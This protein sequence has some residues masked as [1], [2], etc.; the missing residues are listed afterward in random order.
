M[1]KKKGF[2]LIELLAT[3]IILALVLSI[4]IYLALAIIRKTRENSYK[5]TI[6]EI[7]ANANN[8]LL[9]NKG[10]LTFVKDTDT[11]EYQCVTVQKLID[12]GY[13]DNNVVK[14]Q[15]NEKRTVNK[16]DY[17]YLER[18]TNTK[19]ITKSIYLGKNLSNEEYKEYFNKCGNV[20]LGTIEATIPSGW[21]RTKEII[22]IY[23]L[24]NQDIGS[25]DKYQYTWNFD[26]SGANE[27]DN[28]D[29]D[30]GHITTVEINNNGTVTAAIKDESGEIVSKTF[31]IDEIDN[32]G[33][34]IS[35]TDNTN[36]EVSGTVTIPIKVTDV[37][38]GV[39]L[40]SFTKEDIVVKIGDNVVD[41]FTLT[42][43]GN[44]NYDLVINDSTHYG[45]VTIIIDKDKVFDKVE[46]G[47]NLTELKPDV[48]FSSTYTITYNGNGNT[49][50]M[51]NATT[52]PNN[53]DC[54]LSS[55]GFTKTGFIFD[56]WYSE[57]TGGTKYGST[58]KLTSNTT[59]Y[60]HWKAKTLTI[61]YN[62]NGGT[63]G[64]SKTFTYGVSGQAFPN[65][66]LCSRNGY[67]GNGWSWNAGDANATYGW[68][69]GVA[70][71]WI[72]SNSRG[73]ETKTLYAHWKINT[74]TISY[75]GNGNTGGMTNATTCNYNTTCTLSSNG[76]SKNGYTFDGWYTAASGGTK[77]GSTTI[78]T[79]N[80]TVYAHW[81]QNTVSIYNCFD[82][83]VNY[84]MQS[85]PFQDAYIE[86]MGMKILI[87]S[88]RN[89]CEMWAKTSCENSGGGGG[90]SCTMTSGDGP[91][92]PN[93]ECQ[94]QHCEP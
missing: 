47:N 54:P 1:K 34:V 12:F 91:G 43:K 61:T 80:T 79:S 60:A 28:Q 38:S 69:S 5:V 37:G 68:T 19:A 18:D 20:I 59:V 31:V 2:T 71:S 40:D 89:M 73:N 32:V 90:C 64:G 44:G 92:S 78:L 52:C 27:K 22:I 23:R 65:P 26:N 6:N 57:A 13:L 33:P 70:D 74:Y 11:T 87:S 76:F 46:N 58:I 15:I 94:V 24:K 9:E 39:D 17:V 67:T 16:N 93:A 88:K 45:K 35:L 55:N 63:G 48:T 25:T 29:T 82:W 21:S 49:G 75:N 51:T 84:C 36:K 86:I 3:I 4:G 42:N 83:G 14:A 50:G 56:G 30:D 53:T 10:L 8:Y 77:Y 41:T 62:C 81:K 7:E 72:D 66:A 85:G